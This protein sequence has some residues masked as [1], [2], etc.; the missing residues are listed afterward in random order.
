MKRLNNSVLLLVAFALWA[1]GASAQPYP[2]RP[3]KLIVADSAGGAPDQLARLV[4]QKLSESL[5]QP[6]VVD[7]RAGAG[8]VLGAEMVA[9][10]APDGYT[11]LVGYT[12]TLGIGPS[13]HANLGYDPDK[14]LT[15]VARLFVSSYVIAVNSTVPVKNLKELIEL[16]KAKPGTLHYA[17]AGTGSTPHLCGEL[18]KVVAGI[19]IVHVPYKASG[20]AMTALAG[21]ESQIGCQAGGTLVPLIKAGKMRAIAVAAPQRLSSYPDLPTATESGLNGFEVQSWTGYMA[22][23]KTPEPIVRRLYGEIAKIIE[24]TQMKDFIVS[25]GAEP[26]LMNPA[27]FGAYIKVERVKWAKVIKAANIKVE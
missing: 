6:V 16:A 27:A 1:V 17:S 8:G 11:L 25:Q 21:G 9:K 3:I 23:A 22:P 14:D 7:N 26:A 5:G 2:N 13:V 18:L 10:S 24:T 4:A 12:T 19:D 20:S 15:T